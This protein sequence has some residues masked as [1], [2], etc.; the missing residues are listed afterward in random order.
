MDKFADWPQIAK[1][2]IAYPFRLY[3]LLSAFS[4]IPLACVWT[5]TAL[6]WWLPTG[7]PVDFHAYGFLN[8][9]GGAAFAG[10]LFTAMPEWT[11][12]PAT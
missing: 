7:A 10:F 5:L 1:S 9:V 6:G 2:F 12:I 3:F 8:I 4:I 11:T